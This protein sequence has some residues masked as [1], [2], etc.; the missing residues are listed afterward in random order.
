MYLY[1]LASLPHRYD[2]EGA[3]SGN[4][5]YTD[6]NSTMRATAPPPAPTREHV[7]ESS[8]RERTI[9]GPGWAWSPLWPRKRISILMAWCHCSEVNRYP[10]L[11]N[12]TSVLVKKCTGCTTPVGE[13]K[14][15][16]DLGTK[17]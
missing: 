8:S 13:A 10:P 7:P 15:P 4:A 1:T 17:K 11:Y 12:S 3:F 2:D 14:I 5:G 16:S 6:S 9:T